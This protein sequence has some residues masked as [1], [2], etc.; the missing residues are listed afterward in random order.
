MQAPRVT[1]NEAAKLLGVSAEQV[2]RWRESGAL[3]SYRSV[4]GWRKIDRH[5]YTL[6][7]LTEDEIKLAESSKI[8]DMLHGRFRPKKPKEAKS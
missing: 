5:V 4:Q 7:G 3:S 8:E 1:P 6:Y 2:R